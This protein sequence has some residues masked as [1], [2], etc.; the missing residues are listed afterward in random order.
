MLGR[1]LPQ[2]GG[3]AV[4]PVIVFFAV[5]KAAGLGPEEVKGCLRRI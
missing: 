3:E 1:G 4:A 2:F 5:W